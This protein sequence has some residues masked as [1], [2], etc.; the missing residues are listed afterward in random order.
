MKFCVNV[1]K[2]NVYLGVYDCHLLFTFDSNEIALI[3]VDC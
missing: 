2:K 3:N 1:V